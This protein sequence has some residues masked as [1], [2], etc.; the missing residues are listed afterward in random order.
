MILPNSLRVGDKIAIVSLSSGMLGEDYCK[1]SVRLG[2]QRI[3]EFG[4]EPVF[5]PYSLKGIDYLEKHPEKRAKDLIAAFK[6]NSIKGI[7]SSIGGDDTFKIIPYLFEDRDF[8]N[9]VLCNPKV[10]IGFSDTTINHL[11]FYKLGMISF[12]GPSFMC[13][14]AEFG[15]E[16]LPYTKKAFAQLFKIGKF[17]QIVSSDIWYEERNDFSLDSVGNERI[18]H[19]EE[20]GFELLQGP[21][22]CQ[23]RLLGGCLESFFDLLTSK[24]YGYEYEICRKYSLFPSKNEWKN[25]ILFLETSEEKPNPKRLRIELQ[26][27]KKHG[28]FDVLNGII[29]GKPQDEVYY[30]EYKHVYKEVINNRDLPIIYNVNF[31]HAYPRTLLGYGMQVKID[32]N[33]KRITYME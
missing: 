20:H 9:N 30:E 32:M 13:D 33:S 11:M 4:L 10:F 6:D 2:L 22:F 24:R 16:M 26:E 28:V 31:G 27:L 8:C 15:K 17:D 19:K 1:H 12:Y 23:G 5:M 18:A 3:K 25:K 7:I 14:F 29:I 21:T